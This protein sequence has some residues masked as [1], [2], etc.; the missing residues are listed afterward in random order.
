[1][2]ISVSA[3]TRAVKEHSRE[4][5]GPTISAEDARRIRN[6]LLASSD[7]TQVADA[8]VDQSAWATYRQSLRDLTAQEGFPDAIVWPVS[9][10][11][12]L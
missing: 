8:P 10:T 1:M 9:P 6:Q 3:K 11:A 12:H 4:I 2:G 7:W 5:D